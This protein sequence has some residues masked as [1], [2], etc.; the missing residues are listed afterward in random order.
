MSGSAGTERRSSQ[1]IVNMRREKAIPATA[2]AFGV[3]RCAWVTLAC[4]SISS[5]PS[6]VGTINEDRF[7]LSL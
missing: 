4:S 3:F 2:A 6:S 5:D 7:S 1:K